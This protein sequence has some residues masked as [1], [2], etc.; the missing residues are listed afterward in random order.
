MTDNFPQYPGG[1][2]TEA[3]VQPG[4]PIDDPW[5]GEE[6]TV[7][8][9]PR[10]GPT[11]TLGEETFKATRT[12][13]K[14]ALMAVAAAERHNDQDALAVAV[15]DMALTAI[16]PDDRARFNR[17]MLEHGEEDETLVKMQEAVQELVSYHTGRKSEPS[18]VSS[19]S[20]PTEEMPP[21]SRH[22]SF[23]DRKVTVLPAAAVQES[24]TDGQQSW[25][26]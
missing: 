5:S 20:L 7:K 25:A 19:P 16:H 21:L 22:V 12:L 17:Y 26:G 10:P 14:W 4:P 8:T 24:S 1:G 2:F 23:S 11:L 9:E 6:I 15:Y 18:P 3:L 13:N